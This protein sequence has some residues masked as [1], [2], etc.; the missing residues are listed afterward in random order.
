MFVVTRARIVRADSLKT[1]VAGLASGANFVGVVWIEEEKVRSLK[2]DVTRRQFWPSEVHFLA[3]RC[4]ASSCRTLGRFVIS[5]WQAQ[6]ATSGVGEP[7]RGPGRFRAELTYGL[8]AS[9]LVVVGAAQGAKKG[10]ADCRG[11]GGGG[12]GMFWRVVGRGGRYRP[13][14]GAW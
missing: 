10:G 14:G 13:G 6:G 2:I 3:R 11:M 12:Y 1:S 7:E 8:R 9:R 5:G 4:G